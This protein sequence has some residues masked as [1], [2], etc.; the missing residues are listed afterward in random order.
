[1]T[2]RK[3]ARPPLLASSKDR[4]GG[5]RKI[6]VV[7]PYYNE[8][9]YVA[10][11]LRSLTMQYRLPDRIILVDNGSTDGSTEACRE[12][13]AGFPSDR[14][15]YLRD[16]RPG[17]VNA[18]ET[19]CAEA[20]CELV[21]LCDAD[22]TYPP[23]YL[24]RALRLFRANPGAAS[25]MGLVATHDPDLD[26]MTR[27]KLRGIVQASRRHPSKCLTG[28]AG[29]IFRADAL[30]SAGGFSA[31]LWNYVLMDHEIMNRM[32]R[33]GSSVYHEDLWCLHSDRRADRS[34]VRWNLLD[35]ILYRYAPAFLGDWFFHQYL[36][37][38]LA[39]R[40]MTGLNLRRQPWAAIQAS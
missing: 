1:M 7:V 22:V 30:R 14:V 40:K 15:L 20:D 16:P 26:A 33:Q 27:A 9:R 39:A 17:K 25:V 38:R 13:L 12:A 3:T 4:V 8:A 29:Q 2:R 35:R 23:H 10:T 28:G 6:A 32:R 18:L 31:K 24:E 19:G 21:A 5:R 11:T 34:D 37:P 36:G